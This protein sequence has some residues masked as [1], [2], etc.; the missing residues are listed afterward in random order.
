MMFENVWWGVVLLVVSVLEHR[1]GRKVGRRQ[2]YREGW[3]DGWSDALDFARKD[4]AVKKD[5]LQ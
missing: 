1:L 3:H 4:P 2:G 5:V